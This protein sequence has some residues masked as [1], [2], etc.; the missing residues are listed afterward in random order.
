MYDVSDLTVHALVR[1]T[2]LP[3][4]LHKARVIWRKSRQEPGLLGFQSQ[5]AGLQLL[6]HLVVNDLREVA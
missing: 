6:N 3:A 5:E 4:Q 2:D 1:L